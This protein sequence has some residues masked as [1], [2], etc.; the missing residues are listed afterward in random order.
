MNYFHV[1]QQNAAAFLK[2]D[3]LRYQNQDNQMKK[4]RQEQIEQS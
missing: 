3:D 1:L 2:Q 4:R